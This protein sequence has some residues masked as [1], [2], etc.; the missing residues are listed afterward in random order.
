MRVL[1]VIP[2]ATLA[3][4][5]PVAMIF[6]MLE[7]WSRNGISADVACCEYSVMLKRKIGSGKI[8]CFSRN[9]P[10]RLSR[11]SS[12]EAW[13]K[14]NVTGYDLVFVHGVW[15][16][17]AMRAAQIASALGK[18]YF[19]IPHG[20]L[21]PYDLR[22]KQALKKV[23]GLLVLRRILSRASCVL[24]ATDLEAR[25][26]VTYGAPK[27]VVRTVGWPVCEQPTGD[28][29]R[30]RDLHQLND[31]TFVCLFLSR[32]DAKK[33]LLPLIEA[34][35]LLD[36]NLPVKLVVAGDGMPS[37]LQA[38]KT[39]VERKNLS[40]LVKFVGF[41]NK[42]ECSDAFRGADLF[43][44]PSANE[45]F[46]YVVVEALGSDLPVVITSEV[47]LHALVEETQS[48]WVTTSKP[49]D[50]ARI[51]R[52]LVK[53]P[54]LLFQRR[55]ACRAA[56]A[57][58]TPAYLETRYLRLIGATKEIP[59][60]QGTG[61]NAPSATDKTPLKVLHVQG[62]FSPEHGGPAYSLTNSCLEQAR[63]GHAVSVRTMDG[64]RDVSPARTLPREIDLKVS[65]V[66]WPEK[67]GYSREGARIL[68][69][70]AP[71]D[72]YHLHGAWLLLLVQAARQARLNR[73]PYI[74]EMMGSF[75]EYELKRKWLRKT[76]ARLLYQ[77]RVIS[78][79]ACIHVNSPSEGHMLRRIGVSVPIAC[80]PV[81]VDL[82]ATRD[83]LLR[84]DESG[85][86]RARPFV[87]YLGRI[88]PTKG[89]EPL[90]CAWR[91]IQAARP[92]FQLVIAGAGEPAYEAFCRAQSADLVAN[93]SV[94][95]LGKVS[96]EEKVRL[97]RD[98]K[99]YILPSL[100]ENFGNTVAEA[101]ACATPVLSSVNTQ[102]TMIEEKECG[103]LAE[104]TA[105]SLEQALT[106]FF[107]AGETEWVRRGKNGKTMVEGEYSIEVVVDKMVKLYR[108]VIAGDIP[109]DLLM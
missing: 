106:R 79:A 33:G 17:M 73:R 12:F 92:D 60:S 50:L 64:Y 90:L 91:K 48:G 9:F 103:W 75:T 47:Y 88:H 52:E 70:D 39:L 109:P 63:L 13:F 41:L 69:A 85:Q 81:G 42:E 1:H 107:D 77:D 27:G 34:M 49:Q 23:A 101:M 44:L 83:L 4:G 61:G 29:K 86:K 84:V 30:F 58:F 25:R 98:S 80:L 20:S 18:R 51:I 53:N 16:V 19:V 6:G 43:L 94:V 97:Y 76:V 26:L 11:S 32:L 21:D 87:M 108:G 35:Y 40:D 46:G 15:T 104:A 38:A 105:V 14:A 3:Y 22:K 10:A 45:N 36:R 24:C 67:L 66:S 56:A 89:I 82:R 96:E 78:G 71:P 55:A 93:G 8:H 95:W 31:E 2:N 62:L 65:K 74:I 68:V 37:F 57:Q 7:I 72:I 59:A 102:W 100:N 54:S 5:G 99:L 28:R